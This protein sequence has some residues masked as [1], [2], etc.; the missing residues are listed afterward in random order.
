MRPPRYVA[1]FLLAHASAHLAP[2][3]ARNRQQCPAQS[4]HPWPCVQTL[5][6]VRLTLTHLG[7][8][9]LA[10]PVADSKP[11]DTDANVGETLSPNPVTDSTHASSLPDTH[12]SAQA[13]PSA[14]DI[15]IEKRK[16]RAAKFGVPYVEPTPKPAKAK[17][18]A[19]ANGGPKPSVAAVKPPGSAQDAE[20]LARRRAK[21]GPPSGKADKSSASAPSPQPA[22]AVDP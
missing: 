9:Q 17:S 6:H 19:P 8:R 7:I 10:E 15:E 12:D 18:S 3:A 22:A 11:Q 4:R 1:S 16:A 21:F 20:V 2:L 13:A 14:A 5:P